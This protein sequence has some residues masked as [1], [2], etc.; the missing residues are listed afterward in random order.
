MVKALHAIGLYTPQALKQFS[1]AW[2]SFEFSSETRYEDFKNKNSKCLEMLDKYRLLRDVTGQ[3]YSLFIDEYHFP[4]YKE[5]MKEIKFSKQKLKE[6]QHN[7][8]P[9]YL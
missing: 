1:K 6:I 7:F 2:R 8:N 5:E 4:L 9:H 3:E